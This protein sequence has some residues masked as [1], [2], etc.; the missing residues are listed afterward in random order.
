MEL[1]KKYF[2]VPQGIWYSLNTF[3]NILSSRFFFFAFRLAVATG[4]NLG[5]VEK[6]QGDEGVE[7]G[8]SKNTS[9]GMCMEMTPENCAKMLSLAS[10]PSLLQFFFFWG[11]IY[12][13]SPLAF[14]FIFFLQS[15]S[16]TIT[17]QTTTAKPILNNRRYW[18]QKL[19][20]S[21]G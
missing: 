17:A 1:F 15:V 7:N 10:A 9:I 3:S 20:P 16:V 14:Y 13:P 19:G 11:G 6:I 18:R 4:E 5:G 12:S 2:L 8:E 21:G